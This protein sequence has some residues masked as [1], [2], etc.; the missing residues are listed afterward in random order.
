VLCEKDNRDMYCQTGDTPTAL[1]A[2]EIYRA[3]AEALGLPI[4]EDEP[5]VSPSVIPGGKFIGALGLDRI[6]VSEITQGC[7]MN[8]GNLEFFFYGKEDLTQKYRAENRNTSLPTAIIIH[9]EYGTEA[10][11]FLCESFSQAIVYAESDFRIDAQDL[12]ELKPDYVIR[13][14]GENN[15][16]IG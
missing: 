13:I 8:S 11:R 2:Y 16:L 6:V 4:F 5:T 15:I 10:A 3:V 7:E 12:A 9:D 1:G 14:V